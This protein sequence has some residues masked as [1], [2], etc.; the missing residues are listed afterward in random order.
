MVEE[1]K[2]YALLPRNELSRLPESIK[3]NPAF[4]KS[5]NAA[6]KIPRAVLPPVFQNYYFLSQTRG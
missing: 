2:G 3:S 1:I 6:D 5:Y 4:V